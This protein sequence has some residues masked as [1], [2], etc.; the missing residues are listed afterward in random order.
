MSLELLGILDYYLKAAFPDM[1][2]VLF[3]GCN[4]LLIGDPG[5]LPPVGGSRCIQEKNVSRS[6]ICAQGYLCF[7]KFIDV[8]ELRQVFRIDPDDS[9]AE[10]YKAL[11]KRL[12]LLSPNEEDYQT[13][14]SLSPTIGINP[15][16]DNSV[17]R[18]FF[19]QMPRFINLTMIASRNLELQQIPAFS[20]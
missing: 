11:L 19:Q 13:I 20:Q 4:V 7:L 5:Q 17:L 8:F 10:S 14:C 6:G 12:R 1:Q 18:P 3:G 2:H 9:D 15:Q 16:H